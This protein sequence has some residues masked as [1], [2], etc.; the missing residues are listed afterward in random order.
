MQ[1]LAPAV[2]AQY[3]RRSTL[4]LVRTLSH[5][6][7]LSQMGGER[8]IGRL[9]AP[10]KSAAQFLR[11]TPIDKEAVRLGNSVRLGNR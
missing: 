10:T 7:S 4:S 3:T 2:Y 5:L 11:G 1:S 9:I 6:I 8:D